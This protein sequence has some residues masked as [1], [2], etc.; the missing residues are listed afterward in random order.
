MHMYSC[1]FPIT[2]LLLFCFFSLTVVARKGE[3]KPA[4]YAAWK[5]VPENEKAH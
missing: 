1:L 5:V 2:M 4:V 3:R